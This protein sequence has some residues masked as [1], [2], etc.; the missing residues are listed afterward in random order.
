MLRDTQHK[1]NANAMQTQHKRNANPMQR[2]SVFN[3]IRKGTFYWSLPG[4]DQSMQRVYFPCITLFF[5]NDVVKRHTSA[6]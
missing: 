4:V 5:H 3:G 1:A 6:W 2:S